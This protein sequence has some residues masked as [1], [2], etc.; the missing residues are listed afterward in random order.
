MAEYNHLEKE[1]YME[2]LLSASNSDIVLPSYPSLS[3]SSDEWLGSSVQDDFDANWSE[4]TSPGLVSPSSNSTDIN[5]LQ[6]IVDSG[7]TGASLTAGDTKSHSNLTLPSR[8]HRSL[9]TSA[10][11]L[12]PFGRKR[13]SEIVSKASSQNIVLQGDVSI[14]IKKSSIDSTASQ[15]E[16]DVMS[17]GKKSSIDSTASCGE[18][19]VMSQGKKSSTDST[20]S[21]GEMG[22][23]SQGKKSSTD[24]TASQGEMGVESQR[25]KFSTVSIPEDEPPVQRARRRASNF[26]SIALATSEKCLDTHLILVKYQISALGFSKLTPREDLRQIICT[27]YRN[28]E[29]QNYKQ[30][31]EVEPQ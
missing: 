16:M 23:E 8:L 13:S 3:Q 9:A 17:Q 20:T 4:P 29:A 28:S 18:M 12:Q 5:F 25:K 31:Y 24:S 2:G 30:S 14:E 22:V 10:N 21:Q 27:S 15:G 6:K 11:K 1:E 26:L 7:D 19:D